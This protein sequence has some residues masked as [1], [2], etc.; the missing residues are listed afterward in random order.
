MSINLLVK[1]TILIV[2]GLSSGIAVSCGVFTVFTAVGLVPRFADKINGAKYILLFENMI[3]FGVFLGSVISVYEPIIVGE[4]H[5]LLR[6]AYQRNEW[7]RLIVSIWQHFF[8]RGYALLTGCYV[9]C[10]ALSIAELFDAI[11]IMARRI[12]LKRGLGILILSF[13]I[14]KIVGSLIYYMNG[15]YLF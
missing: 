4:S 11:P 2:F 1:T 6:F 10:L 14:G 15:F 5:K 9:S 7:T 3:I 13:A 12:H 8:I